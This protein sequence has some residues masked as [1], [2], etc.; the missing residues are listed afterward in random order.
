MSIIKSMSYVAVFT[1]AIQ[2]SEAGDRVAVDAA[3]S[4]Q[5]G[6]QLVER[7]QNRSEGILLPQNKNFVSD[8]QGCLPGDAGKF[9]TDV[10]DSLRDENNTFYQA[11]EATIVGRAYRVQGHNMAQLF[12]N[13][14][15]LPQTLINVTIAS[16]TP[17][18]DDYVAYG[19]LVVESIKAKYP[20]E[21][22]MFA[23]RSDD[24]IRLGKLAKEAGMDIVR[25]NERHRH[26]TTM[27]LGQGCSAEIM[28]AVFYGANYAQAT[29]DA[30]AAGDL[31]GKVL[32]NLWGGSQAPTYDQMMGKE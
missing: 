27:F 30:Q 23:F 21:M 22:F 6:V 32:L 4:G 16:N 15:S 19:K 7:P 1:S 31:V 29:P 13:G 5:G 18:N 20:T 9:E 28:L 26:R 17:N 25:K 12:P 14:Y 24:K 10:S 8:F 3:A 2:I 11:G